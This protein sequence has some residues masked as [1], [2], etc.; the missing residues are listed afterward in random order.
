VIQCL[1]VHRYEGFPRPGLLSVRGL[2]AP[3]RP[4]VEAISF[5]VATMERLLL[6]GQPFSFSGAYFVVAAR[7]IA[8]STSG[9]NAVS[10]PMN[11]RKA[12]TL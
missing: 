8:P 9:R 1:I 12:Q 7:R 10:K 2:T 6:T 5:V 3:K 11:G 4:S